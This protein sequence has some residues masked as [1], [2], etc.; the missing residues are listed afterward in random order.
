MGLVLVL[1]SSLYGDFKFTVGRGAYGWPGGRRLRAEPMSDSL[2]LLVFAHLPPPHHGQSAMTRAVL[3][4][5]GGDRR[6]MPGG[7]TAVTLPQDP[8]L[9]C[10]HVDCR[11]SRKIEEIGQGRWGKLWR[12]FYYGLE[13]VY[14][15]WR[16]GVR[17][18]YYVPAPGERFAVYRDWLV[19]L[20]CRP[21]FPVLIY[22]WHAAGMAEWLRGQ[23]K[24]WERGLT[25]WLLGKPALSVALGQ[26]VRDDAMALHSKS[27]VV[28]PNGIVDPCPDYFPQ[29]QHQ[30]RQ[31]WEA[32]QHWLGETASLPAAVADG[33][34]VRW[35]EVLFL[36]L[37]LREKGLFDALD[38]VAMVNGRMQARGS[39]VR[40]RLNVAGKFW[41]E[42]DREEFEARLA[43]P[44]LQAGNQRP[45]ADGNSA[46]VAY[47]GFVE[48]ERKRQLFL[49]ADCFCFP[50]YYPAETFGLVVVEA[51]AYGLPVIATRWKT[52]PEILP[53]GYPGLVDCRSPRAIA[54]RLEQC[55]LEPPEDR[56][57]EH[58]ER[59]FTME[60]V[61]PQIR[62]ELARV[63][64]AG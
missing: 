36:S 49:A 56:L 31:R 60:Q 57:R 5:L 24:S 63:L 26:C 62:R 39:C 14:C 52:L 47:W 28:I 50:T 51:M 37:C 11:F 9:A 25:L 17:A 7:R 44:D 38:A 46:V 33:D 32:R 16:Y 12:L 19:M 8:S 35:Y 3:E 4:G 10:Y 58:F 20:I 13:A 34:P 42:S 61:M 55:L 40:V 45:G 23:A 53:A 2:K 41:R 15:R 1:R 22:H 30:R 48:G 29:V 59:H 54:D 6:K 43:K 27:T 64:R 21:F 18:F